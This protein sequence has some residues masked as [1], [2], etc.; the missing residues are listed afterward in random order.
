MAGNVYE[1]CNDRYEWYY[2]T[3]RPN[4][5]V[6]PTG[7]VSGSLRVLRGGSW[8]GNPIG[9]RVPERDSTYVDNPEFETGFRVVLDLD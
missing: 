5:D 2:Y 3:D 7:P 8:F 1:W 6:N 9:C 4:P